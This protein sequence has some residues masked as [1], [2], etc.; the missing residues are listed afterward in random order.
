MINPKGYALAIGMRSAIETW[1]LKFSD[2]PGYK[3]KKALASIAKDLTPMIVEKAEDREAYV[4]GILALINS[5]SF[6]ALINADTKVK[7]QAAQSI[8]LEDMKCILSNHVMGL[9]IAPYLEGFIFESFGHKCSAGV[10]RAA[11]EDFRKEVDEYMAEE[12]RVNGAN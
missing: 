7:S 1:K 12:T 5:A 9:V 2:V 3:I 11:F 10:S 4:A 8:L 6:G